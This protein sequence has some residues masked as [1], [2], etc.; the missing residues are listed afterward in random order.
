MER[1]PQQTLEGEGLRENRQKLQ[2]PP[3]RYASVGMTR[4]V[5]VAVAVAVA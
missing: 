5:L 2:V 1:R 3:L 4:W